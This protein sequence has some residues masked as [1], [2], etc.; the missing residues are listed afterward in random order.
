MKLWHNRLG[1]FY[2][3]DINK[4]INLHTEQQEKCPDCQIAKLKRKPH[5]GTITRAT[6]ILEIIHSDIIGPIDPSFINSRYIITFLDEYSRKAWIYL[7]RSKS[8]APSTIIYL[9]KLITNIT[10]KNI[11]IFRSDNGK[12]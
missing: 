6:E 10:N 9:F 2:H 5:N 1:H 3:D 12:E 8:E 7:L 4:Y 11:K